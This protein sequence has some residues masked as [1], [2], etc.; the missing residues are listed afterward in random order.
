LCT[1]FAPLLPSLPFT[2]RPF[3]PQIGRQSKSKAVSTQPAGVSVAGV[4]SFGESLTIV[5][6]LYTSKKGSKD[7]SEKVRGL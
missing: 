3:T 1:P 4:A 2:P 5:A 6:T 7:F